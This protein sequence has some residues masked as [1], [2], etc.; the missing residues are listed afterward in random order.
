LY[1]RWATSGEQAFALRWRG[2]LPLE[3]RWSPRRE[4]LPGAVLIDTYN[5]NQ[6]I[7]SDLLVDGRGFV[8]HVSNNRAL[9]AAHQRAKRGRARHSTQP[10]A[11][12][13][14]PLSGRRSTTVWTET[15][16][17]RTWQPTLHAFLVRKGWSV[18]GA[19]YRKKGRRSL[20]RRSAIPAPSPAPRIRL[21]AS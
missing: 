16:I 6:N 5:S 3:P 21:P 15:P 4:T 8:G 17:S 18:M 19:T 1:C 7:K 9:F 2:Q 11:T 13:F 20:T 12:R 14:L 10:G